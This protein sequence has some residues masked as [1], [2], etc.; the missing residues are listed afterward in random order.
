MILKKFLGKTIETA[1]KSARQM[2]GDDFLILE[3][4]P[5]EGKKKAGIKIAVDKE[6]KKHPDAG[7]NNG[8]HSSTKQKSPGIKF[9]L[10]TGRAGNRD[11]S[12]PVSPNLLKLRKIAENQDFSSNKNGGQTQG[13]QSADEGTR[14]TPGQKNKDIETSTGN[15]YSRASVRSRKKANG[16]ANNNNTEKR[17]VKSKEKSPETDV[18]QPVNSIIS[19]FDQSGPKIKSSPPASPASGRQEKREIAALHKRFDKLEALLDSALI[20]STL[21]YVSHP[22]FQ[23]LVH[24]G[25]STSVVAGWFSDIIKEGIDPYDQTEQ[26]M[27]KLS[28][29]IRDALSDTSA[30]EIQKFMLFTGP[31]G[32][33][34]THLVMKLAMH[35]EYLLN[36]KVAVVSLQ[37]QT[38]PDNRYYTILEPFCNDNDIPFFKVKS[39]TEVTRLQNQWEEFDHVLIDTPSIS[40]QQDSSF[41]QYWKIRQVF[42]SLAPME[43][44][45]VVNASLNRFYFQDSSAIHHPLQPDYV[46]ITH[47]DEVSQWGPVI[48]FLK[49]MGCGARYISTG[50]S[51]PGSLSEFNPTRFAQ[52]VLQDT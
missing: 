31:S 30:N 2:Y 29:I 27:S 37:P 7:N 15:L 34:K 41:R 26:F 24:T 8:G 18:H 16:S 47:L 43:V 44:H 6:K 39:G 42:V 20:T 40:I 17:V 23:Q 21:D 46:A 10:S 51:I 13:K 14:F 22:A 12:N 28:G 52:K 1:K 5:P 36:K 11:N 25:I 32:S 4:T 9:E 48:P 45:Y 3:S 19:R 35:P 33:G 49:E 38:D 50:D